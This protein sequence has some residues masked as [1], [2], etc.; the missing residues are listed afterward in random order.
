MKRLALIALFLAAVLAG[1]A[2]GGG[3]DAYTVSA[4]PNVHLTDRRLYTSDPSGIL[5]PAAR[6]TVNAICARLERQTGIEAA[7]VMLPSIGDAEVFDFAQD[8]FRQWGL[9]KKGKDNGVLVLF[10]A[11]CRQIRIH[12]GYGLEGVL[13]DAMCKRI[14]TRLM[15]PAFRRSDWDTGMVQGMRGISE[16]LDGSMRPDSA[17]DGDIGDGV[18]VLVTI[19]VAMIAM[20]YLLGYVRKRCPRCHKSALKRV[21]TEKLLLQDGRRIQRDT[22]I[23]SNC[24]NKVVRDTVLNDPN[25]GDGSGVATGILLGS[26]LGGGRS[27]GSFGGSFGGGS[28]GGGGAQSGW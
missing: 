13:T 5:S 17:D 10:V 25:S 4:V 23:C 15:V 26:M 27:G 9:G 21:S 22:F 18:A 28:S 19:V 8:L 6:D 14:Q 16:V 7:V 24:G 11:D 1:M 12:T 3:A 20:I 2:A